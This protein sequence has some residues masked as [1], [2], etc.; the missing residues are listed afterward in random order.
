MQNIQKP[1]ITLHCNNGVGHSIP[2]LRLI[3]I[4]VSTNPIR[5]NNAKPLHESMQ[6]P[7]C[8][9]IKI[10]TAFGTIRSIILSSDH[11]GVIDPR[12]INKVTE[13]H[14]ELKSGV[15]EITANEAVIAF[16]SR[17]NSFQSPKSELFP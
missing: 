11:F 14:V 6:W 12:I 10:V 8:I 17:S 4:L 5:V 2:R 13:L 3:L 1:L 16:S 7:L 15:P 9:K